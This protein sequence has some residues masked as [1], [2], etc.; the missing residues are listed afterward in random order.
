MKLVNNAVSML[1]LIVVLF[2]EDFRF[3]VENSLFPFVTE[4]I[5]NSNLVIMGETLLLST[6]GLYILL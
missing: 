2:F 3:E 4:C 5:I 6:T 1:L